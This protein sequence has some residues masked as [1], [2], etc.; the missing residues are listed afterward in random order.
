MPK[1]LDELL[2]EA[3]AAFDK[4]TPEEQEAM[5]KRQREG[6]VKAEMSWPKPRYRDV[7]GVRIYESYEDYCNV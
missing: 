1:S 4:L 7:N 2:K 3:R 6:V 5:W